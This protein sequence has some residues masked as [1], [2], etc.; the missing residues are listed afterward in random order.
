MTQLSHSYVFKSLNSQPESRVLNSD[1]SVFFLNFC[2]N[3]VVALGGARSKQFFK[4]NILIL[5]QIVGVH[6]SS[7]YIMNV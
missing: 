1:T 3:R 4:M 6:G 7:L 5:H 2:F